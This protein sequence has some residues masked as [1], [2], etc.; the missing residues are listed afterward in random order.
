M[1]TYNR[2]Y[3]SFVSLSVILLICMAL[4]LFFGYQSFHVGEEIEVKPN[5]SKHVA[6]IALDRGNEFWQLVEQSARAEAEQAGIYLDGVGPMIH[7]M[8]EGLLALERMIATGVD[9]IIM[10]GLEGEKA[11][12]L[13]DQAIERGISVV[14]V[15][16]DQE[17]SRRNRFVGNDQYEEGKKI[18]EM[19]KAERTG[20]EE[21]GIVMGSIELIDQQERLAGLKK[22]IE[23]EEHINIVAMVETTHTEFSATQ[24]TYEMLR[25]N[26]TITTLISLSELNGSGMLQGA[27]EEVSESAL[28]MFLFDYQEREALNSFVYTQYTSPEELGVLSV[29]AWLDI[30]EETERDKK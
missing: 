27:N 24:K 2:L 14:F 12:V 10:Q 25:E 18:G 13:V 19:L 15:H 20:D 9:G 30:I 5:Y 21:I 8:E 22:V 28:T 17:D 6:F 11:N 16:S 3:G 1:R 29:R 4:T 26:P 7:D 23:K